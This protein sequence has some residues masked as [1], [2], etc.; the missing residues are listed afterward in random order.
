VPC[1]DADLLLAPGQIRIRV[2]AAGLNFRDVLLALRMIPADPSA[3]SVRQSAE[4]AGI[5]LE[6]G[7]GV[8]SV[9]PG[10]RVMGLLGGIGPVS[11]T[12]A[13]LVCPM[14]RGWSFAQA[15][16]VPVTFLTAH[17]GL[18]DLACLQ[19]GESVLVH[20]A[21][22][23]VAWRPCSWPGIPEPTCSP[24]PAPASGRCCGTR[25]CPMTA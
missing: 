24:R 10:D 17:Q 3:E 15:A 25:A 8:T 18:A 19:P 16:A 6:A 5:V 23:G 20:A 22:G 14:P 21:A 11:V 9:R 12:D 7:P 4:G 13:K 2:L 1:P